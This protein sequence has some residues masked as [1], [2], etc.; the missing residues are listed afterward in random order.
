MEFQVK[1]LYS[2]LCLVLVASL[3]HFWVASIIFHT[4]IFHTPVR[5]SDES[6]ICKSPD[7]VGRLVPE[8]K[9]WLKAI[10]LAKLSNAHTVA[11]GHYHWI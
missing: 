10:P 7:C 3:T 11:L 1:Y 2:N 8:L 5:S 6:G 9:I 4:P